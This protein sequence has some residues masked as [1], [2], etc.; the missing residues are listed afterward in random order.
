M[1][2]T[3]YKLDGGH[4]TAGGDSVQCPSCE[5]ATTIDLPDWV[6]EH[7]G[8]SIVLFVGTGG[9][10]VSEFNEILELAD[11]DAEMEH[12]EEE[13][14]ELRAKYGAELTRIAARLLPEDNDGGSDD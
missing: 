10:P 5:S 7:C 8:Q 3:F 11:L 4:I 1:T 13:I 2:E 12:V 14:G 9:V 6:C